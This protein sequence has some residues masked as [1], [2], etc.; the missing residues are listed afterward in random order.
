[1]ISV[2]I[3]QQQLQD[4]LKKADPAI[5][6]QPLKD[7]LDD[8]AHLG[9]IAARHN[10]AGGLE[11]A[12]FT[13]RSEVRPMEAKVYSLMPVARAMSIEEGR[14]PGEEPPFMQ[15][16]RWSTGRRYLTSRGVAE[17]SR[18]EQNQIREI[19][20]AIM[21]SGAKGKSFIMG[22]KAA[23]QRDFPKLLGAVAKKIESGFGK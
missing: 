21:Q 1:M 8:A 18:D 13:M 20:Q 23:V 3:D 4:I 6:Q 7:M 16:A 10:L 19:Q 22:A 17:M 15:I 9:E 11:Q 2:E 5:L 14:P 12:K